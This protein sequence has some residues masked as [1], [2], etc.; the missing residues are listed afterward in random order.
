MTHP[1]RPPRL[2][3][4]RW[5]DIHCLPRRQP[6]MRG[7]FDRGSMSVVYG[8]SGSGKTAFVL[9]AGLHVALARDWRGRTV[10][11]GTVAYVAC[12]GGLGIEERLT[13]FSIHHGIDPAGVPFYVIPEP[14]DLCRS[15]T[16]AKLLLQRLAALPSDPPLEMIVVDTLSRA[17]AGGNENSPDDMG[18]FVRHCDQIRIATGAHLAAIHHAGKDDGRGAR[19]HSLLRAAADTE[20]EVVKSESGIV[21]A[22]TTKQRDHASGDAFAFK[23]VPVE[24]GQDEEGRAITSC[25]I[26]EADAA[27]AIAPK[28]Q[29][30]AKQRNA[31]TALHNVVASQGTP[32][33]PAF[34]LPAG[35]VTVQAD[36]WRD[37]LFRRGDLDSGGA[38]PRQDF[39]RLRDQLKARNLIGERDGWV[40]AA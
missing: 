21:V 25:A 13:A 30:S 32:A 22:T 27:P 20:V 8:A 17:M 40:W 4:V 28:Q 38:N 1:Q 33:P 9:D 26:E 6:L 3:P 12:E 15:D 34:N 14:I 31:I 16:D 24:I 36:H 18:R 19:G 37:E 10:R 7:L 39:R 35:I 5:D 2:V 29:M 23:L 11:A